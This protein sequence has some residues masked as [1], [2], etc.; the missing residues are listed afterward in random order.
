MEW[1]LFGREMYKTQ[2]IRF[3]PLEPSQRVQFH[4]SSSVRLLYFISDRYFVLP[5]LSIENQI[6]QHIESTQIES[7]NLKYVTMQFRNRCGQAQVHR[8]SAF[9]QPLPNYAAV[10]QITASTFLK[11]RYPLLLLNVIYVVSVASKCIVVVWAWCLQPA[12]E[13]RAAANESQWFWKLISSIL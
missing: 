13:G 5:W 6:N 7:I 9:S 2:M 12:P 1:E 11:V 8:S 3:L 10:M 4:R